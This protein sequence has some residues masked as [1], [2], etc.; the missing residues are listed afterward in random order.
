M[1]VGGISTW[2]KINV[3]VEARQEAGNTARLRR[4]SVETGMEKRGKRKN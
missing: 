4:L 2:T 3:T 1:S